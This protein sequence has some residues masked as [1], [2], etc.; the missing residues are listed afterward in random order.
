MNKVVWGILIISTLLISCKSEEIISKPY[1]KLKESSAAQLN[2]YLPKNAYHVQIKVI[3][4]QEFKGPFS[5]YADDYL[6]LSNPV[7]RLD[8]TTYSLAEVDLNMLT[9]TDGGEQYFIHIDGSKNVPIQLTQLSTLAGINSN[10]NTDITIPEMNNKVPDKPHFAFTDISVH[11]IVD[12]TEE[13]S[14]EYKKIDSSLV[15]VP[16]RKE[17]TVI[18][19]FQELAWSAA[20]FI[21]TLRENR[22]RL[23][24]GIL[25][26]EKVPE[27][28]GERVKELNA[29]EKNYLE[30]FIGHTIYDTLVYNYVYEPEKQNFENAS[31]ILCYFTENE[32]IKP[33]RGD[34]NPNLLYGTP[35]SIKLTPA[36][37][38]DVQKREEMEKIE[39]LGIIYR[40][41]AQANAKIQLNGETLLSKIIPVAQWGSYA[42][43]PQEL[44]YENKTIEFDINTGGLLKISQ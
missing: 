37:L 11:P 38:P 43:L 35:I 42:Y 17:S 26:T 28:I 18:K 1:I 39:P 21:S 13:V 7:I 25:E 15:R 31:Q 29:L 4:K 24:A 8:K 22:F 27:K 32:G 23:L 14:Y 10:I 19:S 34:D 6:G 5:D 41:P 3:R 44:L 36:I 12:I 2:Y 9:Y 33:S 16:V 30:L 40:I 20:K